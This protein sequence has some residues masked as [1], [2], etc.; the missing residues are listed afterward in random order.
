[1][2]PSEPKVPD[3]NKYGVKEVAKI[4]DVSTATIRR[5]SQAG[6]LKYGIH[7]HNGRRFYTGAELKR[8]WRATL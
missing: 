7:R 5:Q 2:T 8:F 6:N 1:M 3:S 4:L